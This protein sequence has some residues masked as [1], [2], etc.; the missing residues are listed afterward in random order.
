MVEINTEQAQDRIGANNDSKL[1]ALIKNGKCSMVNCSETLLF[2][3][4]IKRR[5]ILG[6][7][8]TR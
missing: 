1:K 2:A 6:M 5:G 7:S 8:K 4:K 3:D